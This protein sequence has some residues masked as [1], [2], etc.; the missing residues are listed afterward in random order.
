M[1]NSK[2]ARVSRAQVG[3]LIQDVKTCA[4]WVEAPK[5]TPT[6]LLDFERRSGYRLPDDMKQFYLSISSARI[7]SFQFLPI[8]QF[9]Q[10]SMFMT[11]HDTDE[12]CPKSWY[13]FVEAGV[14]GDCVGIDLNSSDG[15]SFNILDGDHEMIGTCKII[16]KSFTE[17]VTKALPGKEWYVKPGFQSYGVLRHAAYGG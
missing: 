4:K 14:S 15:K 2:P 17:F 3:K 1:K 12:W 6:L 7:G 8:P 11:A 13:A 10:M 5:D 9:D 16:A